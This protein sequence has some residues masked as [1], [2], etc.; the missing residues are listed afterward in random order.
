[1]DVPHRGSGEKGLYAEIIIK[2]KPG[3]IIMPKGVHKVAAG[4][5]RINSDRLKEVNEKHG[6]INIEKVFSKRKEDFKISALANIFVFRFPE[7]SNIDELLKVYGRL[8][9]VIYAEEN[10][11]LSIY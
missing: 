1:M 9:A 2:L 7:D 11:I 5:I 8:D 10:A 3:I 6:L 4:E